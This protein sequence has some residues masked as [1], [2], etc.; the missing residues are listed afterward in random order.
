[1]SLRHLVPVVLSL[2]L[3]AVLFLYW[4]ESSQLQDSR[5]ALR[6]LKRELTSSRGERDQVQF[7]LNL[8]RED[9]ESAQREREES[10]RHLQE[11]DEQL[12]EEQGK[13]VR[14]ARLNEATSTKRFVPMQRESRQELSV[15]QAQ[16]EV[17]QNVGKECKGTRIE[18]F[19]AF[20]S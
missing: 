11:L 16:V 10:E 2:C 1:M 17:A 20:R 19:H 8:L 6:Q 14:L 12:Q 13:L 9:V 3:G 15:S 7:K 4:R 5:L 18:H